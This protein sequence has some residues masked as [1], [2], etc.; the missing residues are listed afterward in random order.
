MSGRNGKGRAPRPLA[1]Y[2]PSVVG[3]PPPPAFSARGYVSVNPYQPQSRPAYNP[4]TS[5][6]ASSSKASVKRSLAGSSLVNSAWYRDE[7]LG[8]NGIRYQDVSPYD[9]SVPLPPGPAAVVAR[10]RRSRGSPEPSFQSIAQDPVINDLA[11]QGAESDV[12]EMARRN[13]FPSPI[14]DANDPLLRI[15]RISMSRAYVPSTNTKY[16][17]STPAPDMLYGYSGDD[18]KRV[19]SRAQLAYLVRQGPGGNGVANSRGMLFPFLVIEV[20]GDSGGSS[21]G[22]L[23]VATNQCLGGSATSVAIAETLNRQLRKA[24]YPHKPVHRIDNAVWSIAMSNSEARLF[25]SWQDEKDARY[26]TRAVEGFL[27]RKPADYILF[28]RYVRN[29]LDWGRGE[30]LEQIRQSLD[31]LADGD[32]LVAAATSKKRRPSLSDTSPRASKRSR[33]RSR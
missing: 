3:P 11:N 18:S 4:A 30:R 16:R 15:D 33:V 23:H 28:R 31:C 13:F 25:V 19:F 7:N 22:S 21:V 20:K 8:L 24:V 10:A 32:R 2:P 14:Y 12:E 5:A 6:R 17:V 26:H 9:N 1:P 29:I 27:I